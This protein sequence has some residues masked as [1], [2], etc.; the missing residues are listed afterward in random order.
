MISSMRDRLESDSTVVFTPH[1]TSFMGDMVMVGKRRISI[2]FQKQMEEKFKEEIS[3]L[4]AG[5]LLLRGSSL[6]HMEEVRYPGTG[7]VLVEFDTT[8]S[9]IESLI[10]L[11]RI[12][13]K[14]YY[15]LI[16]HPER[17]R[18]CRQNRNRLVKL[19]RMGCGAVV[20]AR[21]LRFKKY[22]AAARGLLTDG[23][24]HCLCSDAHSPQ[25][26]ILDNSLKDI[27]Q[28]FSTV[29]WSVLTGEL[30][31]LIL[32]DMKLPE[33]PLVTHRKSR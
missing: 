13:R 9:W 5:E 8:V 31:E 32:N 28:G 23:F 15:P 20:S 19:S 2:Q 11:K 18:W 12:L 3:F 21:S 29:P 26:L 16:A 4:S 27:I 30:P 7:W 17:Y 33:L 1:Y 14:G 22:A 24:C 25:D 6:K 10:Q